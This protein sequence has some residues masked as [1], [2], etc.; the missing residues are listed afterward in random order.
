MDLC[1]VVFEACADKQYYPELDGI[2]MES[3]YI[4]IY[5][6]LHAF[7]RMLS[8]MFDQKLDPYYQFAERLFVSVA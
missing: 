4:Y 3:V 5:Y 8:F 7:S 1:E 2:W 6:D